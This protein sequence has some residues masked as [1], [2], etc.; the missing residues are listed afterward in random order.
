MA[1]SLQAQPQLIKIDVSSY[2]W[3]DQYSM[4]AYFPDFIGNEACVPTSSTNGLTYLQNVV[5][6]VFGSQLSGSSYSDW[7]QTDATLINIMGTKGNNIGTYDEPFVYGLQYYI[8]VAKNFPEVQFTGLFPAD[9]WFPSG[10]YPQ[11][12]F[13]QIGHPTPQSLTQALGAG[14]ALLIGISYTSGGGGHELLVNGLDWDPDTNSGII[15]FVDPLDP[16]QNYTPTSPYV[17]GP[18]KQTTGVVTLDD[19]GKLILVYDQYS[20]SLPYRPDD[21]T[22]GVKAKIDTSLV[23]GGA[24]HT[25]FAQLQPTG[26][27]N[28]IAQGFD[29][30]DPTTSAMF[31]VLQVFNTSTDAAG[32]F[33]QLDPSMFNSILFTEQAIAELVRTAISSNLLQY[34]HPCNCNSC[35]SLLTVWFSPFAEEVKQQGTSPSGYKNSLYGGVGGVDYFFADD[36]LVGSAFSYATGNVRWTAVP[37]K[38]T[39]NAYGITAYGAYLGDPLWVDVSASYAYNRVNARRNVY[40]TSIYPFINS[41]SAESNHRENANLLMGHLGLIY[42]LFSTAGCC[43]QLDLWPFFNLDEIYVHQH[44]FSENGGGALDLTVLGKSTN[45]IRPE[46]GLG[47]SIYSQFDQGYDTFI[48]ATLSCVNESRFCGKKSRAYFSAASPDSAFITSGLFPFNNLVSPT[49]QVGVRDRCDTFRISF[50]YRGEYGSRLVINQFFAE[51]N[52]LF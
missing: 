49:I 47:C 27:G 29:A 8:N 23:V 17:L 39:M 21:Y 6:A 15:Y 11:P 9:D 26:N 36:F 22:S 37:S 46:I 48:H 30:V 19:S 25:P 28:A 45:L 51:F 13:V 43:G 52:T 32:L 50:L 24:P 33:E 38:A 14:S 42:N 20:G 12:S 10:G 1:G 34:R 4:N 40:G 7:I 16:S 18:V 5:P 41:L 35:D 2:G 31:N 3:L 44:S